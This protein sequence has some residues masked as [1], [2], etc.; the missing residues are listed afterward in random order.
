MILGWI[1]TGLTDLRGDFRRFGLLL[2]CLVLGTSVVA[3]IASIG[4]GLTEVVH[5]DARV[6]A[7]GD[8]EATPIGR[9]ATP[10]EEAILGDLGPFVRIIDTTG[11]ATAGEHSGLA[12]VLAVSPGYPAAG[13]LVS[14]QLQDAAPA[15]FLGARDGRFGALADPRLLDQLGIDVGGTLRL[16][17]AEL[18]VRGV[19][20][21]L[22]DGAARGF[23]LGYPLLISVEAYDALPDWR[24]P[25]PGLLTHDRHKLLLGG[26]SFE[27]V[28]AAILERLPGW[29]IRSPDDIIGDLRRYYDLFAKFTLFAGLSALLIGGVGIGNGVASY[30]GDRWRSIAILRALGATRQRL[31]VHF[32]AQ[33]VVL[34]GTGVAVGVIIGAAAAAITLPAIGRMLSA[35]LAANVYPL[36]LLVAAGFGLLVSFAF[37]YPPLVH[38][39]GLTPAALFRSIGAA[40]SRSKGVARWLEY[41]PVLVAAALAFALATVVTGDAPLVLLFGAFA[42]GVAGLLRLA[43]LGLQLLLRHLPWLSRPAARWAIR[44]IYAPGTSAPVAILSIG[45][46]LAV[47]L[48]VGLLGSN[49]SNQLLRGV[50]NDAPSFILSGLLEE[51]VATLADL[52]RSQPDLVDA[53]STTPM[54]S[55]DVVTVNGID[56]RTI[57]NIAEEAE[58]ML[59]GS[60][61]VTF[62]AAVPAQSRVV[63]GQWW[64]NDYAGPPLVSLRDTM[65]LQ[66]GLKVG[67]PIVFSIFGDRIEARVA[68][69]RSFE[70]QSGS[71]LM[72]TFDPAALSDYPNTTMAA[73]RAGEGSEQRL[74]RALM[75]ALPDVSIVPVGDALEQAGS[76][77]EGLRGAIEVM[78]GV[79]VA[80]GVLALA[81]VLASGR[82]QREADAVVT[83]VLGAS[84]R[85]IVMAFL[86]EFT[87]V[88][89]FAALLGCLVG[90][91]TAWLITLSALQVPF[92]VDA[93]L[94]AIVVAGALS[95]VL[96]VGAATTWRALSGRPARY[97]RET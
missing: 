11:M 92:A 86:L 21:A 22:P 31:I 87:L 36:P 82:R 20:T 39:S 76:V 70:W 68:S 17:G 9:L 55:A 67:D 66:L 45:L 79:V 14:L 44:N 12:D 40:A 94:L 25:L 78:V 2:A 26:Q 88:S 59:A 77:L 93:T 90:I 47:L 34:A 16:G 62:S 60:I 46:G 61:P 91:G 89:L 81:S 24:S 72:V 64:S 73:L 37:S 69:F 97:L 57:P 80:N 71:N 41:L 27:V 15:D 19:L 8:L 54:I 58:F 74:E 32:L 18:E 95:I 13:R 42:L 7:G 65:Q 63:A 53:Y 52:A 43:G 23:Q 35:D 48:V 49:L 84:R 4:A 28:S 38:A 5:R 50:R 6:L 33:I 3:A 83:K 75:A 56:P 30:L 96:A 10:E 51:D 85:T 1:R 29:R